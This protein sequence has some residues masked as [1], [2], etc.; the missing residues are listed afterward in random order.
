MKCKQVGL[1]DEG[2]GLVPE[3]NLG[4]F[5]SFWVWNNDTYEQH[6]VLVEVLDLEMLDSRFLLFISCMILSRFPH[7]SELWFSWGLDGDGKNAFLRE[8][9]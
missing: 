7:L 4:V 1:T 9:W 3:I 5:F 6:S 2:S 8:F